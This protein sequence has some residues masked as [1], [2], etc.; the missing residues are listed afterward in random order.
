MKYSALCKR[1]LGCRM[2]QV[3][4][5]SVSATLLAVA[6]ARTPMRRLLDVE[7]T[8]LT[9]DRSKQELDAGRITLSLTRVVSTLSVPQ[10]LELTEV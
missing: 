4:L 8:T 7:E 5:G 1:A 9:L 10:F 2:T 3:H 6:T